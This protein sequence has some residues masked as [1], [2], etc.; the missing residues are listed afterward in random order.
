MAQEKLP[1]PLERRHL[2][3]RELPDEKSLALAEAYIAEGRASEAVIF[4]RKAQA[5]DRLRQLA[6]HALDEGDAFLLRSV[7]QALGEEPPAEHW[8]KLA[9]VAEAAGKLRYAETARRQATRHDG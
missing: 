4:L 7:Q 5:D 9:D 6:D 8:E 3:E 1:S 2:I